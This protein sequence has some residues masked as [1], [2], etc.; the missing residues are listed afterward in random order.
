VQAAEQAGYLRQSPNSTHSPRHRSGSNN[1]FSEIFKEPS[2]A[3]QESQHPDHAVAIDIEPEIVSPAV[4]HS[5]GR[6][7]SAPPIE[8]AHAHAPSHDYERGNVVEVGDLHDH[9][10]DEHKG[11]GHGGHSHSSMNMRGLMLHVMGDALGNVGV[12]A[13]GLII[14]LTNWPGKYYSDPIISLVITV[15]IFASALPLVKSASFILL[16][17]VPNS[18][19]LDSLR[20]DIR[21]VPGVLSL[22][23][24]HVWQLSESKIVASVHVWVAKDVEYMNVAAQIRQVLHQYNV[25]SCTIQP[26]FQTIEGGEEARLAI[27]EDTQCLIPCAPGSDC[28][29]EAMCCPTPPVVT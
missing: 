10:H 23:E 5:H 17:G 1:I 26:E 18:I 12:I 27:A 11:A 9:D 4:T 8:H 13:S 24:L 22:H 3:P 29:R 25:H 20:D 16:Q 14:W 15:I 28:P 21:D 6:H 19:E 2:F 7:A